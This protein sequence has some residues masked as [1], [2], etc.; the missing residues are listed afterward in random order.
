MFKFHLMRNL[1]ANKLSKTLIYLNEEK[2]ESQ[3]QQQQQQQKQQQKNNFFK[4]NFNNLIKSF[5]EQ[6]NKHNNLRYIHCGDEKSE[7]FQK[8]LTQEIFNLV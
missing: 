3:E 2:Y 7:E 4:L 8:K 6:E 5:L 1:M